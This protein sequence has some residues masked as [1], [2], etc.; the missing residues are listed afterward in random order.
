MTRGD[1]VL[2][3]GYATG[4][5]TDR[6]RSAGFGFVQVFG[7]DIGVVIDIGR[8]ART[9]GAISGSGLSIQAVPLLVVSSEVPTA[10]H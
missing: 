9:S 3:V 5:L 7:V 8:I 2:D 1:R 6:L 4:I 10:P